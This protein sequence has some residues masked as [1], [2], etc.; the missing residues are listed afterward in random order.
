MKKLLLVAG[1][2][3]TANAFAASNQENFQTC[4]AQDPSWMSRFGNYLVSYDSYEATRE[5]FY[6]NMRAERMGCYINGEWATAGYYCQY[7]DRAE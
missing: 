3:L 4:A 2:L 7:Q 6:Q 5:C 1:L